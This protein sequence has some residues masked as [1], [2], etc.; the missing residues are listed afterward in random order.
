MGKHP[1][2]GNGMESEI[3]SLFTNNVIINISCNFIAG[4]YER[5]EVVHKLLFILRFIFSMCRKGLKGTKPVGDS[6][7][8]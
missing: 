8:D 4:A 2:V 7:R 5:H 1:V 3:G 6:L